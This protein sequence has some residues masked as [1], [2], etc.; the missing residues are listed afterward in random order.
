MSFDWHYFAYKGFK[1]NTNF[2]FFTKSCYTYSMKKL[3]YILGLCSV[4]VFLAVPASAQKYYNSQSSNNYGGGYNYSDS[5]RSSSP[6]MARRDGS[7]TRGSQYSSSPLNL[8]SYLSPN[9]QANEREETRIVPFGSRPEPV[10]SP[11]TMTTEEIIRE[12][13]R[14]NQEL[15][16]AQE[17]A[18]LDYE[19]RIR[20]NAVDT[21]YDE[22]SREQQLIKDDPVLAYSLGLGDSTDLTDRIEG[23][24]TEIRDLEEADLADS[25]VDTSNFSAQELDNFE[26]QRQDR[27]T[28]IYRKQ[29]EA[30]DLYTRRSFSSNGSQ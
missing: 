2:R 9:Y 11:Y 3:I 16:E 7:A 18:Q 17:Q 21:A 20:A 25:D 1:K 23:L 5:Q 4:A 13:E 24:L 19:K 15:I 22:F 8:R 28:Y 29:E 10:S 6:Y 26:T 30:Q 12:R 14:I 27:K